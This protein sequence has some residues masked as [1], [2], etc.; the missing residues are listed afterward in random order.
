MAR[1]AR[2]G[3]TLLLATQSV[4]ALAML[5]GND[6]IVALYTTDAAVAALAASLLLYAALFQ[7]RTGSRCCPQA[8]CAA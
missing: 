3:Y 5:V 1:A 4:A 2:A 7:F 6:A 8:H